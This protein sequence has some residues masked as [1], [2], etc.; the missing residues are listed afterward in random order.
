VNAIDQP[1]RG[2]AATVEDG[3]YYQ[4]W[5]ALARASDLKAGALLGLD[6]LGTRVV[7]YRDANG[8]PVVQSAYCPHLGADLS[9]GD[10]C[11][12]EV[13]CAYH[14]WRFD[15]EGRCTAIPT[16]EKI[17]AIARIYNYPTAEAWGLIWA[18]NGESPLFELPRFQAAAEDELI[19]RTYERGLRNVDHWVSISNAVDFQ[20][21][22]SVHGVPEA[23]MPKELDVGP[24]HLQYEVRHG[25]REQDG[26]ITGTNSFALRVKVDG[27]ERFMLVSNAPVRPG[28]SRAFYVVCV[29]TAE[30]LS[31]EAVEERLAGFA[32]QAVKLYEED[33]PVLDTIRF[34]GLRGSALV[35][36]DR[37]IARYLRYVGD[38]PRARPFDC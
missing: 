28:V 14:H 20:H 32:A 27:I 21:L 31:P 9:V 1:A 17:P 35:G 16:G 29:R 8:A 5:Y 33:A 11:E 18:F 23:A 24:Y 4:S 7:L 19:Y 3:L 2:P 22:R 25:P 13:R 36:S 38:F 26:R 15:P 6:F 37:H 12:G 34:R 10:L 30:G